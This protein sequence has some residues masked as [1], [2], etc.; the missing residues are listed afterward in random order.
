[1]TSCKAAA[2]MQ[3]LESAQALTADTLSMH[4]GSTACGHV[5][6]I[7]TGQPACRGLDSVPGCGT[8]DFVCVW[9]SCRS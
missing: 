7:Q 5:K 3:Q 4:E 1:V 2:H 6:F 9:L 8:A